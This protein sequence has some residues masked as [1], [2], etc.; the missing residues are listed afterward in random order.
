[1]EKTE[2][3]KFQCPDCE[4]TLQAERDKDGELVISVYESKGG[5]VTP[6][7]KSFG[8]KAG[9]FFLGKREKDKGG[10]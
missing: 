5:K 6:K 1:M 9:D 3:L 2:V 8:E 7:E 10:E 4:A